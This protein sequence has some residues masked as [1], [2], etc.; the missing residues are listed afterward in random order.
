[1][2]TIDQAAQ[3]HSAQI[4]CTKCNPADCAGCF[5]NVNLINAFI[6]GA[7]FAQRWISVEESLPE[8]G[9]SVLIKVKSN[10]VGM[11]CIRYG[12]WDCKFPNTV[13]HWRPITV[14]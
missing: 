7:Q 9:I 3:D 10:H 14:K 4:L 5:E 6:A 11:A 13:T 8:T 2:K 12:T 1:M